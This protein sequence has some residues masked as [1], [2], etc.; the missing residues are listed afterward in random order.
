MIPKQHESAGYILVLTLMIL[1][2]GV[3]L[4]TQISHRGTVHMYFDQTMIEREKAKQLALGGLELAISQLAAAQPK[5]EAAEDKKVGPIKPEQK[6]PEA[7]QEKENE[8]KF[9][10]AIAPV[11][12]RWQIFKLKENLDG[13]DGTVQ[14]A[15]SCEQGK[16]NLNQFFDFKEKKFKGENEKDGG[17][18]KL[19]QDMYASM[20]KFTQDKD[21]FSSFEKFIRKQEYPFNDATE[22]LEVPEFQKA[23]NINLFY[24]PPKKDGE[25][26]TA[27][28]LTDLFTVFSGQHKVQPWFL[29]NSLLTILGLKKAEQDDIEKRKRQIE[30]SLKEK[31]LKDV[32]QVWDKQ[33]QPLYG[34]DFKSL[35]K[36]VQQILDPLF[37]PTTFSVLSYGII[38]AITQ[39]IFAII[40]KSSSAKKGEKPFIVKKLYWL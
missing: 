25:Q 32:A 23:F 28:Y 1:S 2:I 33:L 35:S 21:L 16:I 26:K 10:K 27:I 30:Q 15:I 38:G 5:K 13:I 3:L 36:E 8:N 11:I 9:I 20:K 14:F 18:K 29:S 31:N 12:N 40:E 19:F 24:E 37:E 39:K 34:K 6:K 4:V 22:L 7:A 17:A